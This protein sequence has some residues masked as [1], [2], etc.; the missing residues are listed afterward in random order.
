MTFLDG[1][2]KPEKRGKYG[3]E[4][5]QE[6]TEESHLIPYKRAYVRKR[7]GSARRLP[8][9]YRGAAHRIRRTFGSEERAERHALDSTRVRDIKQFVRDFTDIQYEAVKSSNVP[10]EWP[11]DET[12][13]HH[14]QWLSGV[15]EDNKDDVG[16]PDI[17]IVDA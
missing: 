1:L 16:M 4:D 15:E 3:E 9:L 6:R 14:Q 11:R 5:R 8:Y 10:D 17:D 12:G 7:G 2:P 13:S